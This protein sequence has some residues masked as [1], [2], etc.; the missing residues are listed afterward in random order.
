[1]K[2][3]KGKILKVDLTEKETSDIE[4][5]EEKAKKFLGGS[6]L[7]ASFLYEHMSEDLDPLGPENPLVFMAGPFV[8]ARVP[9]A[10]RHAVCAKSPLTGIWG[11][12]T[13]GGFFGT[14]LKMAGY[15]GV[16][17]FGK[18]EDPVYISI[19]DGEVSIEDAS[20]YW[21]EGFYETREALKDEV[22]SDRARVSA[23]GL[24]GE[25]LVKYAAIM[26]DHGRAAGRTGMGAVMG[27]K[28][29]KAIVVDGTD[30]VGVENPD[31]LRDIIE[32]ATNVPVSDT[33]AKSNLKMFEQHGTMGYLDLGMTLGDPP[34]KLFQSGIFPTR[35]IDAVAW[36]EKYH[37]TSTSCFNCPIACGKETEFNKRGVEEVDGPEYETTVALGPLSE[38][39]DMDSI[40]YANHLC[41]D[42]GLDTIS[43]GVSIAFAMKLFEDGILGEEEA[44]LDLEWGDDEV[45]I[46]LIEKISNREGLGD[47]LAEG[48]EKIA[49]KY[50]VSQE[51]APH[52]KGL[53]IPMHDPRAFTGQAVSYAT[54]PRGACHLKGDF[55]LVDIGINVPE[56]GVEGGDRFK[57]SEE[58][59]AVAARWQNIRELND[60]L[61]LCKFSPITST[62]DLSKVLNAVTGWDFDSDK[63]L[64]TGERIFNLKRAISLKLGITEQDDTLPEITTESLPDGATAGQSPD[65]DTLLTGYYEERD[66]NPETGKPSKEKLEELELSEPAEELYK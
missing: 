18:A 13:S 29:L 35:E 19:L 31:E 57:S 9:S 62:D 10:A 56:A 22:G 44:G 3:Y 53:E 28:N 51:Q 45:I 55:Y 38:N 21:G 4:L 63:I 8:G 27:S 15:D 17:I 30:A 48:V 26:N 6:G 25:N 36:R 60:S 59:G 65:L 33:A 20:E 7:A 32:E 64:K 2:G 37:V 40:I 16:I 58:R 54:S 41:N 12:S 1:M 42:Y 5:S 61:P 49:K 46:D 11:E 52:V 34:S 14:I 50:D 47:T 24:A 23:I 66:W 39:F 43:A